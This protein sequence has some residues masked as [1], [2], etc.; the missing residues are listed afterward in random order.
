[1]N[2]LRAFEPTGAV[3]LGPGTVLTGLTRRVWPELRC[4]AVGGVATVERAR[5]ALA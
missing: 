4:Q 5:E 3:E 1:M 2:A